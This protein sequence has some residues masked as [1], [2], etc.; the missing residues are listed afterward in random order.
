MALPKSFNMVPSTILGGLV[1]PPLRLDLKDVTRLSSVDTD[2]PFDSDF[3]L[4]T[5]NT[6]SGLGC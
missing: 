2:S 5:T 3:T 6:T 1:D 4:D